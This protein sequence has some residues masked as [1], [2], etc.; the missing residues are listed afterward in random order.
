VLYAKW[1]HLQILNDKF[2]SKNRQLQDILKKKESSFTG[3]QKKFYDMKLTYMKE[4]NSLRDLLKAKQTHRKIP[5]VMA[6]SS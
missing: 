2:S 3:S 4:L 1:L 6:P 5:S